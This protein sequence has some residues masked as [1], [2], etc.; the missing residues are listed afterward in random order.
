MPLIPQ[1]YT[2]PEQDDVAVADPAE[3]HVFKLMLLNDEVNSMDFIVH[4]L[5]EILQM[6]RE[7][8]EQCATLAHY[9]G[10]VCV[11]EA[12]TEF[13]LLPFKNAFSERGVDTRIE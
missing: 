6:W 7:Q 8:A 2:R 12:D 5:Q 9:K 3:K 11:K 13:D 4:C 1:P 10:K